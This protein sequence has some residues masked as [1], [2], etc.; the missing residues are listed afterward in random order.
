MFSL[1]ELLVL[2]ILTDLCVDF[3][4]NIQ[5][6]S[7]FL[8]QEQNVPL[9]LRLFSAQFGHEFLEFN[10]GT[11]QVPKCKFQVLSEVAGSAVIG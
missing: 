5:H 7:P 2:F 6:Q 11:A 4:S 8:L 3:G 9:L 10:F 1:H